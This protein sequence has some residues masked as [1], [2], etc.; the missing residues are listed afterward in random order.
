[1]LNIIRGFC[2]LSLVFISGLMMIVSQEIVPSLL[3]ILV[4]VIEAVKLQNRF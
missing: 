2:V 4:A 3:V 1:M